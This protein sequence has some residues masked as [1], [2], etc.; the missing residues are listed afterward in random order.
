MITTL[1][2]FLGIFVATVLGLFLTTELDKKLTLVDYLDLS[3]VAIIG[4]DVVL[5]IDGQYWMLIFAPFKVLSIYRIFRQFGLV[6]PIGDT[7]VNTVH[8]VINSKIDWSIGKIGLNSKDQDKL[9]KYMEHFDGTLEILD[10]DNP[11]PK[12]VVTKE[13]FWGGRPTTRRPKTYSDDIERLRNDYMNSSK[14]ADDIRKARANTS[15]KIRQNKKKVKTSTKINS[16]NATLAVNDTTVKGDNNTINGNWNVIK[17]DNLTVNGDN[18]IVK[19]DNCR[20]NG[21]GNTLK[22]DNGT[23]VGAGNSGKGDNLTMR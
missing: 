16:D 9:R 18:N 19:G 11:K 5:I 20:V 15:A 6:V 21:N 13:S 4:L 12:P 14:V 2:I 7:V 17:G 23:L 1:V 22:G 10:E 3:V 8:N